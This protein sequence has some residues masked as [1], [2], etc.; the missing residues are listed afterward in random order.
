MKSPVIDQREQ[1]NDQ[2]KPINSV[3]IGIVLLGREDDVA[4]RDTIK[5]LHEVLDLRAQLRALEPQLSK[6]ITDF[7][8]RRGQSGYR[9]FYLRNELNAQQYTEGNNVR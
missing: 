4:D 6:A 5:M 9:E 8:L 3:G 7:G 1:L 2:G